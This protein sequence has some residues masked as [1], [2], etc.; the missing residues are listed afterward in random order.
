MPLLHALCWLPVSWH[1][2]ESLPHLPGPRAWLPAPCLG[3]ALRAGSTLSSCAALRL[4]LTAAREMAP[5]A[6]TMEDIASFRHCL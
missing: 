1:L 2:P 6:I 3:P 5:L 4:S